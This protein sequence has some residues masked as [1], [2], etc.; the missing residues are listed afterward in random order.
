MVFVRIC[1]TYVEFNS[2]ILNESKS[3]KQVLNLLLKKKRT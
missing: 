1:T 3:I 2:L